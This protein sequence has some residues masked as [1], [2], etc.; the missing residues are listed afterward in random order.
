MAKEKADK[1]KKL[2]VGVVWN[3][4]AE[5]K[6]LL[7]APRCS[8][9][10]LAAA[11]R[12][13]PPSISQIKNSRIKIDDFPG[14]PD[15]FEL[16]S[17]FCYDNGRIKLT[18]SNVCR[19]QLCPELPCRET[20]RSLIL[21]LFCCRCNVPLRAGAVQLGVLAACVVVLVPMAMAG[22]HLSRNK[23]LFFSGA[24]FI[25]LA[26]DAVLYNP[27]D[28]AT[29]VD[30]LLTEF[31]HK[32]PPFSTPSPYQSPPPQSSLCKSMAS[33]KWVPSFFTVLLILPHPS[34]IR[35]AGDVLLQW[36]QRER[37]RVS[38]TEIRAVT[39]ESS[40]SA[41]ARQASKLQRRDKS[42]SPPPPPPPLPSS[43][44]A[45]SVPNSNPARTKYVPQLYSQLELCRL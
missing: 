9:P 23:M 7:M 18:V 35:G 26:S 12:R 28:L 39:D 22:Y 19:L 31:N 20:T 36:G 25:T 38:R 11:S 42:M 8:T 37:S 43:Y 41:Q 44:P 32:S 10:G 27:S 24:L 16:V 3:Y 45:K 40:S 6:L 33:C 30:S 29:W 17:R 1:E 15:G 13:L 21:S 5:L 34:P 2:F 14:G 4:A